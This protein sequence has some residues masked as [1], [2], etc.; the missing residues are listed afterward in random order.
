[1]SACAVLHVTS[2]PGGGVDRHVRDIRARGAREHLVWHAGEAADALEQAREPRFL[3]LDRAALATAGEALASWLRGQGVGIVHL[4]SLGRPARARAAWAASALGVP[5]LVT[6]HDVLFL[7]P[8]AFSRGHFDADD[9]W[10]E[11]VDPVLRGAARVIAP[12]A[13]IAEL[14]ARHVE[15]IAPV[16]VANGSPPP[17]MSHAAPHPAFTPGRFRR[18]VAAVGAIGPHKGSR[19]L[20]SLALRLAGSDTALV[21]VGYLDSQAWPGWFDDHLFV[22]GPFEEAQAPALL[23]AYGAE[24]VLFANTAPES[25]SYALSD[26]WSA[27]L[28]VIVPPEGALAERVRTNGGGWVLPSGFGVEEVAS[29]LARLDTAGGRAEHAQVKSSLEHHDARR[30]PPL[31]AMNDALEDLY[32]RFGVAP[33]GP[34]EVAAAPVQRLLASQLDA[35]LFRH[36]LVQLTRDLGELHE[37]RRAA[38]E[39]ERNSQAWIA[40]LEQDVATLTRELREETARREALER[41]PLLRVLRSRIAAFLP[42][43]L[44]RSLGKGRDGRG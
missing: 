8:D 2:I 38:R 42:E 18:I 43:G 35:G 26:A 20:E 9:A 33:A 39:F 11:E 36:E 4:H 17:A 30:L 10:L 5:T 15:G 12:S 22:H 41:A 27:G 29:L 23:R 14:A 19:L 6:L 21:V 16:V 25:F 44:K 37:A 24:A 3:P 31:D 7:R 28:P 40:K 34:L 32:R 1:M 13:F